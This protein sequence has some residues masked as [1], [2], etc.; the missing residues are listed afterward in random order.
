MPIK[1]YVLVQKGFI[2]ST[3]QLNVK[4]ELIELFELIGYTSC[5]IEHVIPFYLSFLVF[6]WLIN[7]RVLDRS[8]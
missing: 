2:F 5:D 7:M 6:N 1:R 4:L 3:L 8:I